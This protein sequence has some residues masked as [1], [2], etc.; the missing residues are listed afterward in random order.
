[1]FGGVTKLDEK[2]QSNFQEA[3]GFLNG[4]LEGNN[5]VAGDHLTVADICLVASASTFEVWSIVETWLLLL[6]NCF[7]YILLFHILQCGVDN[8]FDNYPNIKSWLE[9]CKQ[10]IEGYEE[11]NAP[12][13]TAFGQ[14]LKGALAKLE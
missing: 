1:M 5:Y 13:A 8:V 7:I 12:G 3:L 6:S 2:A 9:R 11:T 14:W 10:E 4:F